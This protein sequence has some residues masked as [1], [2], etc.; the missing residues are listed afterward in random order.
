MEV[1]R[2]RVYTEMG[3]GGDQTRRERGQVGQRRES[4]GRRTDK[5]TSKRAQAEQK[6]PRTK[7]T[8]PACG[9]KMNGM[10]APIRLISIPEAEGPRGK[11]A[12]TTT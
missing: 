11:E 12:C 6:L 3:G 10:H 8:P 9:S 1:G 7:K 5:P 2:L 4:S